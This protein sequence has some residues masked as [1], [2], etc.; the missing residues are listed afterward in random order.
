MRIA[1]CLSGHSRTHDV[2]YKFWLKNLM[3]REH[4]HQVDVFMHLWDT[5]GPRWF[6][7]G[8]AES[9]NPL[10]RPDFHSGIIKS[11]PSD[12]NSIK[13]LWN[14]ISVVVDNYDAHHNAFIRDVV[15]VLNERDRRGI[16]AGFEHHHPLS[17]R[18]MLYKRMK[19]NDL[20]TAHEILTGVT[21]DLVIQA[22]PDVALTEPLS[23]DILNTTDKIMFHNSRSVTKDPEICDFGAIGTSARVDFYCDLYHE[24]NTELESVEEDFFQFLNPHKMYVRYFSHNHM[25][26]E[27][28]DLGLCIVRET[29]NILGWPKAADIV[30]SYK[31]ES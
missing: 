1:L 16:P 28:R 3:A 11:D 15:P 9:M 2:V 19:C 18:S 10:P 22:R 7:E 29:G 6:G 30:R 24:L 23:Q 4:G 31:D 26:Y 17:V 27:E 8:H 20:K 5:V 21:Y 13:Q 12:L 14:P 25:K